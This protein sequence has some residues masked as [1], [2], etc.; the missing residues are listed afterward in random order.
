MRRRPRY[1]AD[2]QGAHGTS[3]FLEA[4]TSSWSV[5]TAYEEI[6]DVAQTVVEAHGLR[7]SDAVQ[8]ASALVAFPGP[9]VTFVTDDA[10]LKAAARA[11]GFPVLP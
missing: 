4:L 6:L 2:R 9:K 8:L 11:E 3:D 7:S 5:I 10:E 1:H